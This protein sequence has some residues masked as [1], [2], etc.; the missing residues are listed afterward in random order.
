M[1]R[2]SGKWLLAMDWGAALLLA[3][4]GGADDLILLEIVGIGG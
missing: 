2:E 3:S 1:I 4:M